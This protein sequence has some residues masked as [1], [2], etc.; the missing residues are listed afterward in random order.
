MLLTYKRIKKRLEV[1]LL[2][3]NDHTLTLKSNFKTILALRASKL[4]IMAGAG[5]RK[6]QPFCGVYVF[7]GLRKIEPW[8]LCIKY[9]DYLATGVFLW[10]FAIPTNIFSSLYPFSSFWVIRSILGEHIE[11]YLRGLTTFTSG[12]CCWVVQHTIV[13][14][15][16]A[17]PGVRVE[18]HYSWCAVLCFSKVCS[19]QSSFFQQD[20]H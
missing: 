7:I 4:L 3:A 10:Q 19:P 2:M 15:V 13:K 8:C 16:L 17:V 6:P 5:W 12:A 11:H 14:T 20:I 18:D 1:K 9:P